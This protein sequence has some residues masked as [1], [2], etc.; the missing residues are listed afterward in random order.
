MIEIS[1]KN[2]IEKSVSNLL[3]LI[4]EFD[5]YR[6]Y[7]GEEFCI[8][9]NLHSPLRDNDRNPSFSVFNSNNSL[10]WKDFGTGKS[11][12]FIEFVKL[13]FNLSFKQALDKV[14]NDLTSIKSQSVPYYLFPGIQPKREI[15]VKKRDFTRFD[16]EYWSSFG[17]NQQILNK[18]EVSALQKYWLIEGNKEMV[19]NSIKNI[20]VYCYHFGSYKYRLYS[21]FNKDFKWITNAGSEILQGWNQLSIKGEKLILSKSLKDVMTLN[22]LGFEAVAPQSEHTIIPEDV[23]IELIRRFEEI[24]VFFDNDNSGIEA[25]KRYKER[26]NLKTV[27]LP[28]KTAKDISDYYKA[29][30]EI[31]T[32]SILKEILC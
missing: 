27:F 1:T 21:P 14:Y 24:I 5:I 4:T 13:K 30:G 7:L 29:F 32:K 17:I 19:F 2:L 23:I 9:C 3:T 18:Y 8:G 16:L 25:S 10:R 15:K 20:S 28:D 31:C 26:Y 12:D 22:S 6:F 11:G